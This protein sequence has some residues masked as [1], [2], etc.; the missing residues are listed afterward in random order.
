MLDN[1]PVKG[2]IPLDFL[3][4]YR[5]IS[6]FFQVS[7]IS[8]ILEVIFGASVQHQDTTIIL[9]CYIA[10]TNIVTLHRIIVA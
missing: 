5:R 4:F 2:S 6:K 1:L 8:I 7:S 9:P 3:V 10:Y